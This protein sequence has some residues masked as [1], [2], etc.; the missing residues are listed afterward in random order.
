MDV[1]LA[2]LNSKSLDE[3]FK[4]KNYYLQRIQQANSE[5]EGEYAYSIYVYIEHR[6]HDLVN[7][8]SIRTI[9]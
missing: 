5:I 8:S 2:E 1:T 6:I 4:L 7:K 9:S 3:L